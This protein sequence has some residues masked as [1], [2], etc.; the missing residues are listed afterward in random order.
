MEI[1][2]KLEHKCGMCG[3]LY[4]N[5]ID[6][7]KCEFAHEERQNI[8]EYNDNRSCRVNDMSHM[9]HAESLNKLNEYLSVMV[10]GYVDDYDYED[11]TYPCYMLI[12]QYED[13]VSYESET[14]TY[15][16]VVSLD[17]HIG[18]LNGAKDKIEEQLGY[19][20][21]LAKETIK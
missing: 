6:C 14:E 7:I 19:K 5:E 16:N 9:Y 1:I 4:N 10:R 12:T 11:C 2:N 20:I 17:E 21:K 3:R 8:I 18:E 15:I 13:F